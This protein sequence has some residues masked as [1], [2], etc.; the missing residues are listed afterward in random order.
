V[1]TEQEIRAAAASATARLMCTAPPAPGDFIAMSGV[2]EA[3]IRDGQQAAF[4]LC[5]LSQE[6]QQAP[7]VEEPEPQAD[8]VASP[9]SRPEPQPE[10]APAAEPEAEVI[11]LAA[12]GQVSSKQEG[13]RRIIEKQRK[14]R[15]DALVAQA[16]VA[17]AKAHKQRILDEAEENRLTDYPIVI[18][19][20]PITLGAYLA[21]VLGS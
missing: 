4:A 11:P 16:T 10:P 18:N 20:E 15:V 6:V 7:R 19:G 1:N 12:R 5:G 17:K 8:P 2:I 21:S 13:A 3:Y 14:A 9:P